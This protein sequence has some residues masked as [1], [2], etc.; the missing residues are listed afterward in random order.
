[1]EEQ[2]SSI[3]ELSDKQVDDFLKSLFVGVARRPKDKKLA[4]RAGLLGAHVSKQGVRYL[5]GS[6]QT[7]LIYVAVRMLE[8]RG[9]SNRQACA[10]V[11]KI[12]GLELGKSRRGR[13]SLHPKGN[14]F[15]RRA[16]TIR[17]IVNRF[18]KK[19]H[20]WTSFLPH[21]DLILEH[22]VGCFIWLQRIGIVVGSKSFRNPGERAIEAWRESRRQIINQNGD[23]VPTEKASL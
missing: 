9:R 2:I 12:P 11:A 21:R 6:D 8:L 23:S 17:S 15:L 19:Q 18:A 22:Y 3:P 10:T 1:V 14:E 7:E 5:H 16:E 4:R 13:P 20:P